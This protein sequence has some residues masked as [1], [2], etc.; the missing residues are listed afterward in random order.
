MRRSEETG[1]A[2]RGHNMQGPVS[3]GKGFGACSPNH[4]S[5]WRCWS[6]GLTRSDVCFE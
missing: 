1:E 3:L 2:C 4:V 6:H 5:N